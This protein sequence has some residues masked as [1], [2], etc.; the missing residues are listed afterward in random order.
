MILIQFFFD[1]VN[2]EVTRGHQRPNLVAFYQKCVIFLK[3]IIGR[4]LRKTHSIGLEVLLQHCIRIRPIS[5][6]QN[7]KV[8]KCQS[9]LFGKRG[10]SRITPEQIDPWGKANAIVFLSSRGVETRACWSK[11]KVNVWPLVKLTWGLMVAQVG[12]V[13]CQSTRL[14]RENTLE[15]TPA[16]YL[17]SSQK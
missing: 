5:T 2:I 4:R 6:V 1:Q 15:R 14:C 9:S 16:L 17:Y 13:A 3:T 10:C 7:V 11:V 12:H 8:K